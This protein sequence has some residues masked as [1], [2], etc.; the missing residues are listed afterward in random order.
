VITQKS[1][2]ALS[3]MEIRVYRKVGFKIDLSNCY[4]TR[5]DS[6]VTNCKTAL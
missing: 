3:N 1:G 5:H 2:S 4:L 6:L